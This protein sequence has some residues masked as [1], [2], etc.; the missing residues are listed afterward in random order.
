MITGQAEHLARD[1]LVATILAFTV[2][3][4]LRPIIADHGSTIPPPWLP[5]L[6]RVT[7]R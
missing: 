2:A 7:R 3:S 6:E 1:H 5:R 4:Q